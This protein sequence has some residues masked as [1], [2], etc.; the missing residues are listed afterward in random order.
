V[1]GRLRRYEQAFADLDAPFAFVDLDAMWS[2]AG[3]LLSRAVDKPI[4]V[5]SKSLRCRAIQREILDSNSRFEGLMTFTLR[6]TLWLAG[7]GFENLLLAYPTTDRAALR[8]LGELTAENPDGAPIVMVDSVEH[9]DIIQN[10]TD[11]P[12]RLCLD[13]DAGYWP[14][15]GR[16][17]IGPKRS[18]LHTPE[19]ARA[20]AV[21]IGKRPGL[22]LVA[23]MSYEGHIAGFGDRVAGKRAQNVV[24]GWM[25]RQSIAELS[26]RRARAVELVREVADLEIVNA[27]GTGD[28]QLVAQEPAMTEATAGSGFYAPTLFD[29]YSSFT[30]Q[31]AAMFVLPVS[32]RPD[33]TTVTAL[34]GGYLA[35]GV[36]AKD[37]MPTPYLP[38]GLK[39]NSMEGTGE[40]QTPLTGGATRRLK[41][42]DKVYFRHTKAGEMCERFDL[43]H[44]VSGAQ[45]VDTVPTY[46]GEGRTFL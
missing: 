27:G 46:R 24:V 43:L 19:Q 2:N 23:L 16:L 7:H 18:P 26:Q 17:K 21:E 36:G 9:L 33:E 20:L 13:L 11:R 1:P 45:I 37:R 14:A 12:V 4:R 29:T 28:L 31:P 38:V 35:S 30:L 25:Q 3:Q 32:R 15:G 39:L 41:V 42:G 44:L 40:V 8:E 34:G 10:A 22:K 5:A 6:E